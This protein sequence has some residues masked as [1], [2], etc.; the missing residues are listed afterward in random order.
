[1]RYVS[2]IFQPS[3]NHT[4]DGLIPTVI[5]CRA[6]H[7]TQL[8]FAK[9]AFRQMI[10]AEK[11]CNRVA[12]L[13]D[14]VAFLT[15]HAA[16]NRFVLATFC[17][18]AFVCAHNSQSYPKLAKVGNALLEAGT[19]SWTADHRRKTALIPSSSDR[20]T[21]LRGLDRPCST[22]TLKRWQPT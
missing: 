6:R 15:N 8:C 18:L 13:A 2:D 17:T 20:F 16:L 10:I 9:R 1:V 11:S 3:W 19:V 7:L 12:C 22:G 4:A 14:E 5:P 21:S